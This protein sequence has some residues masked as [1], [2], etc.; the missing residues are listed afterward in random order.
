MGGDGVIVVVGDTNDV[1]VVFVT[2]GVADGV[3]DGVVDGVGG[4]DGVVVFDGVYGVV[5]LA[6]LGPVVVVGG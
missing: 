6:V 4:F 3:T 1:V 2:D 5:G